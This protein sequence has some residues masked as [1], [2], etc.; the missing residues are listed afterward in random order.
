M[1]CS[2]ESSSTSEDSDV[3][4]REAY[5]GAV[6]I[7]IDPDALPDGVTADAITITELTAADLPDLDGPPPQIALRVGPA[8]TVFN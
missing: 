6:R 8:G 4:E 3:L 7:Y 2:G 1:A 5:D